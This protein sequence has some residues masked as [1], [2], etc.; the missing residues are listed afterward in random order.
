MPTPRPIIAAS[1]GAKSAVSKRWVSS[2]TRLS[3]MPSAITAVRTG[4]AIATTEPNMISRTMIA[5]SQADELGR[6]AGSTAARRGSPRRRA[7]PRRPPS[8]FALSRISKSAS[9]VA[10]E[11]SKERVVSSRGRQRDGAVGGDR[12]PL[13]QGLSTEAMPLT[14]ATW[15]ITDCTCL[16]G[17]GIGELAVLARKDDLDL[18]ARLLGE[19]LL[20]QVQC[21]LRIG[22]RQLEVG[23][24]A[25]AGGPG[26]EATADEQR[27]PEQED[28]PP[29]ARAEG[30]EPTHQPA[31]S[32]TVRI[33]GVTRGACWQ[34]AVAGFSDRLTRVARGRGSGRVPG[35]DD[36]GRGRRVD[37]VGRLVARQLLAQRLLDRRP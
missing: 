22:I 21:P 18:A 25:R 23:R 37:A 20:E 17:G 1:C 31:C 32:G 2:V 24:E 12:A 5:A 7:R 26:G 4:S 16:L 15:P 3:A 34:K 29:A 28:A 19:L 8:A 14:S 11:T 36:P 10:S 33:R 13:A 27:Q 9:V 35:G 6:V 30:S